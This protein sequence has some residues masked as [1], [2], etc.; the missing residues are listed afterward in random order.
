[1]YSSDNLTKTGQNA[2]MHGTNEW[3]ANVLGTRTHKI[4]CFACNVALFNP[5]KTMEWL[6]K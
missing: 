4:V 5:Q 6:I 2:A 3:V 1:M